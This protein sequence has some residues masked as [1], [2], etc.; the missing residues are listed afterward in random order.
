MTGHFVGAQSLH[1]IER[2]AQGF[3]SLRINGLHLVYQGQEVKFCCK[4][5]Q[6][7]FAKD[8]DKFLKKLANAK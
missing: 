6:K 7:D 1:S 3:N 2:M 5:C 8:P 4:D